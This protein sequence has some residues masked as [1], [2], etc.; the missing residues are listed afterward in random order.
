MSTLAVRSAL[1]PFLDQGLRTAYTFSKNSLLVVLLLSQRMNRSAYLTTGLAIKTLSRLSKADIILH[2]EKN[3]PDGSI[4]FV[5]NHFTRVETVLLPCHIHNLT[6]VPVWSLADAKLF[7]GGLGKFFDL[8]GTVSTN[9]PE[10]DELITSTLLTGEANWIIFP[11]GAMVKTKKIMRNG[12][13]MITDPRGVRQ[14]HTGAAAFAL[15]SELF[16]RYFLDQAGPSEADRHRLLQQFGIESLD[17]VRAKPTFIVP[18][19]LTYYP[20]RALENFASSLAAKMIKDI[21]ERVVEEIMTEGTMLLSGVDLDIRFGTPIA[22]GDYLKDPGV[23]RVLEEEQFDGFDMSADLKAMLRE[24]SQEIMQRYMHA[25]YGMTTVNHDHLFA[26]FLRLYPFKK[27]KID[28]LK[29]RVFFG[30][31]RLRELEGRDIYLHHAMQQPQT[32]LVTDDRYHKFENFL[33]LALEKQVLEQ[34]GEYLLMNRSR[35]ST[36]L[37]FHR[38]RIDNPVE[39]IANEVEP[40]QK[41]QGLLHSLAWQPDFL[42]RALLVYHLL[43]RAKA[44]YKADYQ[45][46]GPVNEPGRYG[47]GKPY[48]LP[49][50]TRGTGVVLVHSYLANPREVRSLARYLQRKGLWVYAPRLPG[51]G[52]SSAD[53]ANRKNEEWLEAVETGYVLLSNICRKVVVGGVSVGGCLA[54]ELASRI[55]SVSG[56]FALCPPYRLQDF[57]TKFMPALDV[58][59][60]MLS[61][62]RGELVPGSLEFTADNPHV[63]YNVNPYS[64]IREVGELL[65][66]MQTG[67]KR[68]TQPVMIV[69]SDTDPIVDTKSARKVYAALASRAKEYHLVAS[70]RHVLVNGQEARSVFLKIGGFIQEL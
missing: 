13:Y 53:L 58:W 66:T 1:L 21:S 38:G 15:R 49:G 2:G 54:L 50:A 56:V 42:L 33:Q 59:N 39:I 23:A 68:V 19:N 67:L 14:P 9:D 3:I 40:L 25:I 62:V 24:K 45:A 28:N 10:R 16:R 61:K 7:Q 57:S 31:L 17:M 5:I 8:V 55:G 6:Q 60:R 29:R 51:H 32:H 34:Q 46:H 63:N 70:N 65:E 35:L 36:P 30:A 41:L 43:S 44:R 48:I 69:Q 12:K 52:T 27:I 18:V 26:A 47:S 37:S 22:V 4:I 64:G 20:I 11:E